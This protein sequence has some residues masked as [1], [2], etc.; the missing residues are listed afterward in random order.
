MLY[1]RALGLDFARLHPLLQAF[2]SEAGVP[3]QGAADVT[4][5]HQPWLRWAL[6][7]ARMPREGAQVPLHVVVQPLNPSSSGNTGER[8]TRTFAGLTMPSSQWLRGAQLTERF[9]PLGLTLGNTVHSGT[10]TQT[11]LRSTLL[12]TPLPRLCRLSVVAREWAQDGR[13]CFE[14]AISLGR[15]R[16]LGYAGWLVP[17]AGS[18]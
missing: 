16:L 8:W 3:W 14:V 15:W 1:P 11:G 12:G 6:W 9:G 4:W 13:F 10:L 2:H 5:P 7:L 18:D 17:A